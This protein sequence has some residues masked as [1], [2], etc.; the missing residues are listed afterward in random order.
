MLR[1]R[2]LYAARCGEISA[3]YLE[4]RIYPSSPLRLLLGE[5]AQKP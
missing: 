4:Y 1:G 2:D 3:E 5:A